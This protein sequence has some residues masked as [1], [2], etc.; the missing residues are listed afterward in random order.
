MGARGLRVLD[1]PSGINA[2][3]RFHG[4]VYVS[5][6]SFLNSSRT[7]G[8]PPKDSKNVDAHGATVSIP[9]L[10]LAGHENECF[11]GLQYLLLVATRH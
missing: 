9:Y 8:G 2:R 7:L 3:Q 1:F 11:C 10:M 6:C 4:S 5:F